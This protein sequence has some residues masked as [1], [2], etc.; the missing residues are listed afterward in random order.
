MLYHGKC[1]SKHFG[2]IR[3]LKSRY[4]CQNTI[5]NCWSV[6]FKNQCFKMVASAVWVDGKPVPLAALLT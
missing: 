6:L 5:L 4:L 1:S 2:A 3:E